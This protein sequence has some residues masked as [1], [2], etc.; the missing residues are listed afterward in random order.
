MMSQTKKLSIAFYWHMHQPV[1]QLTPTGDYLMPW[2]RLHAVKDYLDMVL[3]LEKFPKIKLNFNLVPVLLDSLIDYGENDLHDIHSRL[4]ITDV[5]DLTADDKEFIINNFFDANFHSMILPSEEYNRLYQKYQLN[6]ENDINMFSNQEYSDLMA[7]FNLAWFDPIYKNIYPELKKLIKKGK[8]YTTEDR[9]KII[10]IQ[11]D[12]IRKIIPTYKKFSDEGRI[13]ITTSPYYHPILPILLDIKSI[14]KSSENDLPT[15][16][17]MEL[18]ARMQTEMA[19]DRMENIFGKRPRGIWPSEHCISSKEL[20]LLKELGVDWT[21]SDEGI[22]SN[23]INFEFV[24]DF[25]GYLEDPYHLLKSYKYKDDG[26]NIIFR[27]SVIPNL[28]GFEYPNH[29]AE[30]AANDLYDRIKV[31]QS[32]LLSSPDENHLITIAMDGENCWENYTADGSTFLST[33]YS[34]IENDPSLETVLISDYLD[35]DIQK[36]LN[37]ISS[38]SWVN[39]N[40][41]LWIDEPLK[42]LAWTYLKQVRDDFSAYV[43]QNPLNPNIEAARRELF[44]C[45]GSDW[46][47]WYGEPNDSGRDNIFDYIFREHLK[48]I[49][50]FLGLEVPQYLDTPLL[51]AITKPSRYPKGEFTP[52][53]D[54]KEKDDENWLNAGCIKIPDGPVLKED[55]FYDKICFGYDKDNLYLRFYI[56]EYLKDTPSMSKRVNQMYVYMRN[57]SRKQ[58]LSP[59]RIIQKTESLLPISKEKF[60]NEMQISIYDG[61]INLVRLVKAIPNNLWAVTS[62]KEIK[63]V[64]DKVVDI[65]IPFENLGVEP[66]EVLEFLFINANYGVKDF[67]IPND[68]LLTIKRV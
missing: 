27:D 60:H 67:Y 23:S 30:S 4:T 8:D 64:Y 6:P 2:V 58:S 62:S 13:E 41:K 51:S 36:P 61:E 20:G 63:A 31:A 54:G 42:N 48:N 29:P 53:M 55:K 12:I 46:F 11:R 45:E 18:D 28:I 52:V 68:M 17:K 9:I 16:L 14:K 15:N 38:G 26:V 40:F 19:L 22:L 33:I 7:L 25:R 65:S 43:K 59:I 44:I 57:Q 35:K 21:I 39:R 37:K 47:W 56:N 5:E 34:L 32:K 1:Y 49:Y 3:I 24:R 66:G 10:D 50:L